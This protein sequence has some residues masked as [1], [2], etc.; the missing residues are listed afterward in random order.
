MVFARPVRVSEVNEELV[1]HHPRAVPRIA[2]VRGEIEFT[3]TATSTRARG[4]A[5]RGTPSHRPM[6][7]CRRT[8]QVNATHAS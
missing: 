6:W 7:T 1:D 2:R 5:P 4:T 3:G 8:G